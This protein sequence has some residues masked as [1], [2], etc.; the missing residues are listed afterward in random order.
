MR[1]CFQ[2]IV[3]ATAVLAVLAAF[4]AAAFAASEDYVKATK[5]AL[6]CTVSISADKALGSGFI[7]KDG[8]DY[9]VVTS[10]AVLGQNQ[11]VTIT[12]SDGKQHSAELRG[13]S[14]GPGVAVLKITDVKEAIPAVTLANSQKV[15][16]GEKV[17]A[18]GNAP[19]LGICVTAGVVSGVYTVDVNG[20]K[21]KCILTDASVNQG[22]TGGPLVNLDGEVIGMCVSSAP[23]QANPQ[24]GGG[25]AAQP[26]RVAVPA[27]MWMAYTTESIQDAIKQSIR[28]G[29]VMAQVQDFGIK[30]LQDVNAITMQNYK[31]TKKEGALIVGVV[32]DGPAAKAGLLSNDVIVEFDGKSVTDSAQLQTLMQAVKAGAKVSVKYIGMRGTKLTTGSADIQLPTP[33]KGS[34]SNDTPADSKEVAQ[35]SGAGM[36][37]SGI[38]GE[39]VPVT[40]SGGEAASYVSLIEKA[41]AQIIPMGNGAGMA[42]L[43][44][45]SV[46]SGE[47]TRYLITAAH[48]IQKAKTVK[49]MFYKGEGDKRE[50]VAVDGTVVG[51][52]AKTDIA[53]IK[54][55]V[56]GAPDIVSVADA[57][58]IEYGAEVLAVGKGGPGYLLCASAGVV[59]MKNLR[60]ADG[61]ASSFWATSAH[62]FKGNDGGI[63]IDKTGRLVGICTNIDNYFA[64]NGVSLVVPA[65]VA[66]AAAKELIA[67]GKTKTGY[68]GL[69][70]VR[71]LSQE[72]MKK[73]NI[74]S[75]VLIETV[76]KGSPAEKAGLKEGQI[77]VKFG[78]VAVKN[79]DHLKTLVGAAQIGKKTPVTV[80]GA[81]GKPTT[82]DVEVAEKE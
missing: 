49:L 16:V 29:G 65:E 59:S 31:M 17:I 68:L 30:G 4:P 22:Q 63:L 42:Y 3:I 60:P 6:P 77:I 70:A 25:A 34:I 73:Y 23:A 43:L 8:N 38:S 69:E 20:T 46:A 57:N 72:D 28:A 26:Q 78:D 32:Q 64:R 39:G 61:M 7:I 52:D 10:N 74:S 48:A 51:T 14:P 47:G 9:Y 19:G 76:A 45:G 81:D 67:T 71:N 27:G 1:A 24:P 11:K 35:A 75:G 36:P 44:P 56:T 79:I 58:K 13:V 12:T 5:T 55:S 50:L 41:A 40:S 2:N 54:V 15:E 21:V 66:F 80:L 62:V 33:E 37:I 82:V 53:V 18:V